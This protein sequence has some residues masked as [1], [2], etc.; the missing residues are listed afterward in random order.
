ME[1]RLRKEGLLTT[2]EVAEV[3]NVHPNTVRKWT[4][5][6]LLRSYRLGTRRDA[7]FSGPEVQRFLETEQGDGGR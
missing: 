2:S 5:K 1:E 7:R 6:G 4:K 3:L